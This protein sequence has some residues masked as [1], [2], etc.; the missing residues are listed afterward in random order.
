MSNRQIKKAIKR[1]KEDKTE[2]RIG[3]RNTVPLRKVSEND[4]EKKRDDAL[5]AR[6]EKRKSLTNKDIAKRSG[7]QWS[8]AVKL[9]YRQPDAHR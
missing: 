1:I 7:A 5:R 6:R 3:K 9:K 8:K 2:S 4:N